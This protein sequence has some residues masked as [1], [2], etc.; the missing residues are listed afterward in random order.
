MWHA[1]AMVG[2]RWIMIYIEQ[3]DDSLCRC[4]SINIK[5]FHHYF[6][7]LEITKN[8]RSSCVQTKRLKI[9]SKSR[10]HK[11]FNWAKLRMNVYKVPSAV[12]EMNIF[13]I[14]EESRFAHQYSHIMFLVNNFQ[15][16]AA[17]RYERQYFE[18]YKSRTIYGTLSV[19]VVTKEASFSTKNQK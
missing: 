3:D 18:T 16:K 8:N 12:F 6:M 7:V 11:Y 15:F 14:A 5:M 9:L 1:H 4:F 19:I 2:H 13:N 17:Y 10:T